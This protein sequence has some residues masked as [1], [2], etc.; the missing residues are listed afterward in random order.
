MIVVPKIP[1][2]LYLIHLMLMLSP[3]AMALAIF[4]VVLP[5]EKGEGMPKDQIAIFQTV[6]AT[7]AVI[8]VGISQLIPRFIMRGERNVPMRKYTTMKIIQWVMLEGAALFIAIV[9]YLTHEKNMLVPLGILVALMSLMR[10]T[11][12]ELERY[13]IKDN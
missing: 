12:Y 8:A 5:G 9:F 1:T 13:N 7:L 3:A 10:P 2:Q 11:I 4:F 6:A